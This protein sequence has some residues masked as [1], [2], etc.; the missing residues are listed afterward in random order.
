MGV[1]QDE[2]LLVSFYFRPDLSAGSF[3]ATALV[4]ALQQLRPDFR[5][6]VLTTLPNRYRSFSADAAELETAGNLTVERIRMPA[7]RSGMVDQARS[8]THFAREVRR[9]TRGAKPSC[10]L[11]T[12]SRLMTA[13][14]GASLARRASAP[15]VLDI[16]DIFV[17][18]IGDVLRG[19]IRT[20]MLPLLSAL[21]RWAVRPATL[22]NLVSRGFEPWFRARYPNTRLTFYS[23]G[24]D[25]EFLAPAARQRATGGP[26]RITYA[27][28][29]GEGQGLEHIV[30]PLALCLGP[31]AEIRVIGDGGRR[32]QLAAAIAASGAQNVEMLD[33]MPRDA[34]I[35]EYAD[36]DV[37]FLHLNAYDAFTKVLP[38]KIFEYGASQRPILAGVAGYAARFLRDEVVNAAVFN[39]CDVDGAV[40]AFSSLRLTATPRREFIERFARGNIMKAFATDVLEVIDA[41][42]GRR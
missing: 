10:V 15:L 1:A 37:L 23:N 16:R 13:A 27:G 19:P 2:L 20:P 4:Q 39:P 8:F 3:R 35:R 30:P 33:P 21:E 34:L 40:A 17:D 22:L 31:S 11:A 7:H 14:L 9:R 38:S 18:T 29:L 5:I 32:T 28:N 42:K 25:D 41:N 36:S 24:V 6:R 12:S 26:T